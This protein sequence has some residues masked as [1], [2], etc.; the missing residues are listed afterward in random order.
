M[1][2]TITLFALII[3]I[4]V[5]SQQTDSLQIK[6]ENI[7][8]ELSE[9]SCSCIDSIDAADKD[10]KEISLE[11]Q[12][13]INDN[14]GALQLFEKMTEAEA[15]A[16]N[17]GGKKQIN[18]DFNTNENSSEYKKYYYEIERYLNKNCPAIREKA[19]LH[20]KLNMKSVSD[21]VKARNYYSQGIREKEENKNLPKALEYFERAVKED[22]D[23]P[24]AWDNIGVINRQLGNYDKA[25]AAYKKSI[26][27]DPMGKM[28]L[29][30]LAVAYIYK[31]EYQNAIDAYLDL[32][33]I[34]PL[35]PE[36]DYGI[37]NIY[38]TALK[39]SEKALDYL[40]K[41]YNRYIKLNSPYRTDAENL[42]GMAY[43]D[44]KSKGKEKVFFEILEKNNISIQNE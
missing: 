10:H 40:C 36:V 6:R 28:P 20:E 16:K 37:G 35:S 27:L 5:S 43:K 42:I 34:D 32:K 13:C 12:T 31:K 15:N 22:P 39:D 38:L 11:I 23:F 25:I 17:E 4:A 21:N 30:N 44:L 26:S 14:V 7:L 19:A 1:K 33:K 24:F 9:Q 18:I 41:A 8:R 29:Q 2:R 3:G